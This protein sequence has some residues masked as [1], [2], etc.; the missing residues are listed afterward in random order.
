MKLAGEIGDVGCGEPGFSVGTPGMRLAWGVESFEATG[1]RGGRR[2]DKRGPWGRSV[3][4]GCEQAGVGE[5]CCVARLFWYTS[6]GFH[7]LPAGFFTP[8]GENSHLAETAIPH[9]FFILFGLFL[10]SFSAAW[11]FGGS[12]SV[13]VSLRFASMFSPSSLI[14]TVLPL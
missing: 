13:W 2:R 10:A 14:S 1:H 7:L 5:S 6:A 11:I 9:H 4:G 3:P 8:P 12:L